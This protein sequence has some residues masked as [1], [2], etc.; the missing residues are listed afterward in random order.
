MKTNPNSHTFNKKG[1]TEFV[2][3]NLIYW[4][5]V[6]AIIVIII[7]LVDEIIKKLLVLY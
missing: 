6:I 5:L 4:V 3:K 1:G 7:Y 2:T